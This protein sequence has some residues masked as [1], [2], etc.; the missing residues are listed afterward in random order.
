MVMIFLDFQSAVLGI[1][2]DTFTFYTLV[3]KEPRLK[4]ASLGNDIGVHLL[5][6]LFLGN[7]LK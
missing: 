7:H 6:V 5:T 3:S 1:S 2:C 4:Q